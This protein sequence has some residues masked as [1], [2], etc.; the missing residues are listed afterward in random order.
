MNSNEFS[1]CLTRYMGN[2][3]K[4]LPNTCFDCTSNASDDEDDTDSD[5]EEG[6]VQHGQR[7]TLVGNDQWGPVLLESFFGPASCLKDGEHMDAST[8]SEFLQDCKTVLRSIIPRGAPAMPKRDRPDARKRF[9]K[10]R[11]NSQ[12]APDLGRALE[13]NWNTS[14]LAATFP[15]HMK[16]QRTAGGLAWP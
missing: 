12:S 14:A 6:S 5:Q 1:K 13:V 8:S 9:Y 3:H 10:G 2:S 11:L 15:S 4:H 7:K 16:S